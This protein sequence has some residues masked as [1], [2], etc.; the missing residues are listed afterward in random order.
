MVTRYLVD[1]N[2]FVYARGRDHPSRLPCRAVL[3]AGANRLIDLEASV[4]LVQEYAHL[5]LRRGVNRPAAL[6]EIG[7]V[8]SQCRLHPFDLEV[9]D[10]CTALLGRYPTL[11]VRDAVHAA[12]AL[13]AGITTILSVDRVFDTVSEIQR[14]DPATPGASWLAGQE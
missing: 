10:G 12:T 6:T 14:Y 8:R 13:R 3:R 2:V 4:E 1:T 7:E 11:G 5:L 9:L